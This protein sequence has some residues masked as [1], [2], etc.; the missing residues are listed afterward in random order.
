M[1]PISRLPAPYSWR[2]G[3]QAEQISLIFKSLE[4]LITLQPWRTWMNQREMKVS[5]LEE[6][7]FSGQDSS[8]DPAGRAHGGSH[9]SRDNTPDHAQA[10]DFDAILQDVHELQENNRKLEECF[11]NLKTKHLQSYTEIVEALHLEQYR[12][13]RLEKQLYDFT[14]LHQNEI[15]NLKEELASKEERTAYQTD[16][17]GADI[18]EALEACQIRLFKMEQQQHVM[19]QSLENTTAGTRFGELINVL[20]TVLAAILVFVSTMANCVIPLIK[21][22]SHTLST[23]LF[24][25][26]FYSLWKHWDALLDYHYYFLCTQHPEKG[27]K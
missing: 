16:E 17:R 27:D 15:V 26:L 20:Q 18:H 3:V 4:A 24:A 2:C 13:E 8:C 25:G 14:E 23:L 5:A 10:S 22:F 12:C 6:Q 11:E 9:S 21:T 7:G 19:Q 1:K